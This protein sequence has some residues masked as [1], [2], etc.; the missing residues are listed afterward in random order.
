MPITVNLE[1]L[2]KREDKTMAQLAKEIELTPADLSILKAGK[3]RAVR[4]TT[5]EKLCK[6]LNCTVGDLLIYKE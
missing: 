3:A 6:A 5:L 4:M 1:E 2:L